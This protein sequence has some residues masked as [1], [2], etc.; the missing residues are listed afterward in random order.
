MQVGTDPYWSDEAD[1]F[2]LSTVSTRLTLPVWLPHAD[3]LWRVAAVG[4]DGVRGPWSRTLDTL[5]DEPLEA[6]TFTRGWAD[7]PVLHE[8]VPGDE[9]F[10]TFRWSPVRTAS[11]YQIQV[12]D[13]P[14]A[15]GLGPNEQM[16]GATG[17][18]FT[19]R[20][21]MTPFNKQKTAANSGVGNCWFEGLSTAPQLFWRVRALDA[22]SGDVKELATKPVV[23]SGISTQPPAPAE[24]L[25]TTDC[26]KASSGVVAACEP[27]HAVEKGDW[28]AVQVWDRYAPW[29]SVEED[30]R[31]LPQ[32]TTAPLP[33][34]LCS[35]T[36]LCR[37]VPTIDWDEVPGA[38]FYRT[39]IALDRQFTNIQE[40]AETPATTYTPTVQ[41]RDSG[42]NASYYYAVQACT[43]IGCG[44]VTSSPPA[45][46]KGS[47][48]VLLHETRPTRTDTVLTWDHYADVLGE[49]GDAASEAAAYRVQVTTAA[50]TSFASPVEDVVTDQTSHASTTTRY[51]DGAYLWRVQAVDASG[52]KL[53]WSAPGTFRRDA[54]APVVAATSGLTSVDPRASFSVVMSEA[55]TGVN[56]ATAYLQPAAGGAAVP[57]TVSVSSGKNVVVDP[58][59]TL[60][61]GGSYV[62][63]LTSGIRDAADNALVTVK[64]AV[65]VNAVLDDANGAFTYAGTWTTPS[66]SMVSY[67]RYHLASAAG[68]TA[69]AATSGTGVRVYGCR[70]PSGGKLELR[71]DGVVKATVDTYRSYSSCGTLAEVT[72][73]RAGTHS[74]Q[75]K[76]LGTRSSASKGTG[77][78]LDGLRALA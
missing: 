44:P 21:T 15:L 36:G 48:P 11:E 61:A 38:T 25:D 68:A 17:S 26:P 22:V 72:G 6:V 77:V 32:V 24:E 7:V 34:D 13:D 63:V 71:V 4:A 53:R 16:R 20:T 10:P 42:V 40:I 41:W 35:P 64:K 3:Y 49:L 28:S 67:G 59:G 78:G 55:V 12:T 75:V 62:L 31:L 19:T 29:P 54:T 60:P 8:Q 65:T 69:T 52:H 57:A 2:P 1:I 5:T 47:V 39:Y 23:T 51:A 18:C 33:A 9:Y 70:G 73:L 37:D 76:V 27:V 56:S 46:R 58:T 74:V 50:D 45:Y 43:S 14:A 30:H 66:S